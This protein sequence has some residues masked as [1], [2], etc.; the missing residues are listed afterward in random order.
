M[1][2]NQM[3]AKLKPL[4]TEVSASRQRVLDHL[5]TG[6][7]SDDCRGRFNRWR[8]SVR[9]YLAELEHVRGDLDLGKL[10]SRIAEL[11]ERLDRGF[12]M[13]VQDS[14]VDDWKLNKHFEKLLSEL[15]VCCDVYAGHQATR[16]WLLTL[17]ARLRMVMRRNDRP[18]PSQVQEPDYV[19]EVAQ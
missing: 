17:D 18:R 5:E 7:S 10:E 12:E 4:R 9:T 1:T 16:Q 8:D 15:E 14:T 3:I 6:A 19:E 2:T 13:P 11:S